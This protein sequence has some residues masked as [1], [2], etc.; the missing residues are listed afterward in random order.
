LGQF[1]ELAA[2]ADRLQQGGV[3]SSG[4]GK[5]RPDAVEAFHLPVLELLRRFQIRHDPGP[6]L[7]CEQGDDLEL[8]AHRGAVIAAV[9]RGLHLANGLG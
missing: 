3:A 8:R 9:D 2:F 5:D 6:L 4:H 7:A 1:R